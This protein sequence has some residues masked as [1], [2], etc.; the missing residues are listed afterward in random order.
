MFVDGAASPLTSPH[1]SPSSGHFVHFVQSIALTPLGPP[2]PIPPTPFHTLPHPLRPILH[3]FDLLLISP[4]VHL[5]TVNPPPLHPSLLLATPPAPI[6]LFASSLRLV[7]AFHLYRSKRPYSLS[8]FLR[9]LSPPSFALLQIPLHN[10][11]P[12]CL[13]ALQARLVPHV[14]YPPNSHTPPR[15]TSPCNLFS[16]LMPPTP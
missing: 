2:L 7:P 5:S 10:L 8:S 13:K 1:T 14:P 6:D 16:L 9:S 15:D 4:S 12:Y 11:S 3:Q